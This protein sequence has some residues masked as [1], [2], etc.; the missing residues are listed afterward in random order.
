[1][2]YVLGQSSLD[3]PLVGDVVVLP[4]ADVDVVF[5]FCG[6]VGFGV[7]CFCCWFLVCWLI[8]FGIC[9]WGFWVWVVVC[10]GILSFLL[11]FWVCAVGVF[12]VC[13]LFFFCFCFS[14]L[15]FF[16]GVFVWWLWVLVCWVFWVSG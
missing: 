13:F 6:G 3:T 7:G 14:L 12:F 2:M 10:F 4:S 9:F 5:F 16:V 8:S 15:C 1:M 11:V